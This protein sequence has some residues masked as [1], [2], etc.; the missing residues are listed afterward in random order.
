MLYV[1]QNIL[2]CWQLRGQQLYS[3]SNEIAYMHEFTQS[4]LPSR[5]HCRLIS[6]SNCASLHHIPC[7]PA[8]GTFCKIQCFFKLLY[9]F[10]KKP[11]ENNMQNYFRQ[12]IQNEKTSCLTNNYFINWVKGVFSF[13]V[14]S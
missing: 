2:Q 4:C 13:E 11:C 1:L 6:K 14:R 7:D 12:N 10:P 8:A 9:R 3:S 5:S